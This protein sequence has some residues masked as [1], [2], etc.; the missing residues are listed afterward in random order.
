YDL[1]ININNEV[2]IEQ[3]R[4]VIEDYPDARLYSLENRGRDI[5]PFIQMLK[6]ILPLEYKYLLKIHSKKSVHRKDGD[7]WRNH[8]INSLIGSP[9]RVEQSLSLLD[10]KAGIVVAKGNKLLLK[11]WIGSNENFLKAFA[12]KI[13]FKYRDDFYFPAGSMFWARP[14]ILKPLITEVDQLLFDIEQDQIDGTKAHA[15]ERA[16]GMVCA[17]AKKDII[18]TEL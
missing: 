17:Q 14:E 4:E 2:S 9:K 1:Y 18:E 13:G 3:I 6:D 16:F 10:D 7:R 8:L 12:K 15:I 5:L 11:D